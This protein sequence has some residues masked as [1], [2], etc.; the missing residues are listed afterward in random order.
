MKTFQHAKVNLRNSGNCPE[1]YSEASET[2]KIEILS[3]KLKKYRQCRDLRSLDTFLTVDIDE[4]LLRLV[5][6]HEI[7]SPRQFDLKAITRWI[8]GDSQC[9]KMLDGS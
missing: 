6:L 8:E 2:E 4:A 9:L 3:S 1:E 5:K 7:P